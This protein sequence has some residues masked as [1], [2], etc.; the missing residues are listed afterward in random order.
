MAPVLDHTSIP[1]WARE[2]AAEPVD[3]A[4]ASCTILTYGAMSLAAGWSGELTALDIEHRIVQLA[5]GDS[6]QEQRIMTEEL[7]RAVVGWRLLV[8]GPLSDVLRARS[9]ALKAG[10]LGAEIIVSTTDVDRL[11]VTC[12]H[13]GTTT[14][15]MTRV[16]RLV[17]CHGCSESLVVHQHLSPLKGSFLGSKH[18]AEQRSDAREEPA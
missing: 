14:L 9:L 18:D 8:V 16:T 12:A 5:P 2:P 3:P 15:T 17:T 7:E 13:C 4:A 1:H 6:D 11:P 10:L